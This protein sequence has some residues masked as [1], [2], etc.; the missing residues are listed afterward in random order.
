MATQELNIRDLPAARAALSRIPAAAG[1]GWAAAAA[2]ILEASAAKPGN[3]HPQASFSD[4]RFEDLLAAAVA[5]R[6]A[7]EA[8]TTRPLGETILEAVSASRRVT[9]SNANLGIVL[10]IAP[11]AAVAAPPSPGGVAAVLESLDARDA[12]L[13][14]KAFAIARPG[15]LGESPQHDLADPPPEDILEA[16]AAARSRDAIAELWS[17]RYAAFLS[18]GPGT[19]SRG[20]VAILREELGDRRPAG[21][22][23]VQAFLRRLAAE[24]DSLIARRHGLEAAV[25]VSREAADILSTD[26]SA[27]DRPRDP[28]IAAFARRLHAGGEV[29]GRPRPLNPGTTADLVAAGLFVLLREGWRIA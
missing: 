8:A 7:M 20:M 26:D 23:I 11:L 12:A 10:A 18:A 2:S 28:A 19:R 1:R 29:A 9:R 13:I 4:L 5:I 25:E 14:W 3:V 16:M 22:G 27:R 17:D 24:P 21:R 6:P 15:G